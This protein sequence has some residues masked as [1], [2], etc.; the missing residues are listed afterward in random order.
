MMNNKNNN[1][2]D[3][4]TTEYILENTRAG[5]HPRNFLTGFKGYMHTDGYPG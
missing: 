4:N 2:T 1:Q 3:N 5:K